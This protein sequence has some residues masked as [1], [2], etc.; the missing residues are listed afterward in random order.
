[1][2]EARDHGFHW[3]CMKEQRNDRNEPKKKISD[4]FFRGL[5]LL[6]LFPELPFF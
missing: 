2:N 6:L 1:M 5:S 3:F 4:F